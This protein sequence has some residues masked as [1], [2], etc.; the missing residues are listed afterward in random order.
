M[1]CL[2]DLND[3][4]GFSDLTEHISDEEWAMLNGNWPDDCKDIAK[5]LKSRDILYLIH[6]LFFKECN[7]GQLQGKLL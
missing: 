4:N 6:R 5:H 7:T 2:D 3:F 1:S